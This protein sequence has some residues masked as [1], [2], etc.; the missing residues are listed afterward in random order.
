MTAKKNEYYFG[1]AVPRDIQEKLEKCRDRGLTVQ[2][3][4]RKL[5]YLWLALPEE[6]QNQLYLSM[7]D[8]SDPKDR[9]IADLLTAVD[10]VLVGNIL[11]RLP[12]SAK[13]AEAFA[14]AEQPNKAQRHKKS[15]RPPA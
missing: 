6:K 11:A 14:S 8:D 15:R 2:T 5:A 9:K 4:A 10:E 3:I 12:N 1:G 13:I 7:I